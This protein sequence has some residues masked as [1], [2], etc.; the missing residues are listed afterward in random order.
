MLASLMH[1]DLR[2]SCQILS[3]SG[4]RFCLRIMKETDVAIRQPRRPPMR[5]RSRVMDPE[6]A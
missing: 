5:I 2:R 4:S 3:A 6:K 1:I